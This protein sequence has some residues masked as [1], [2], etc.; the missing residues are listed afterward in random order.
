MLRQTSAHTYVP[1]GVAVRSGTSDVRIA[2]HWTIASL[3]QVVVVDAR[4]VAM[5]FLLVF[6]A[7]CRSDGSRQPHPSICALVD[8]KSVEFGANKLCDE[9]VGAVL[10]CAARCWC[11]VEVWC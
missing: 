9:A 3:S 8:V 7:G 1:I 11:R 2:R 10:S 4:V 6:G 5:C